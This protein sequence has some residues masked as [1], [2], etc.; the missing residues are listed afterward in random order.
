M[1]AEER[2]WWPDAAEDDKNL[3][4]FVNRKPGRPRIEGMT[5]VMENKDYSG[6]SRKMQYRIAKGEIKDP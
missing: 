6:M 4:H 5:A 2:T 3:P 1:L